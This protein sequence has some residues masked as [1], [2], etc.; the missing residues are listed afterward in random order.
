MFGMRLNRIQSKED[1][2]SL[3]CVNHEYYHYFRED[4]REKEDSRERERARKSCVRRLATSNIHSVSLFAY[5]VDNRM[6]PAAVFVSG[7]NEQQRSMKEGRLAARPTGWQ[8][9]NQLS[10]LH[11]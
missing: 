10:L 2:G 11:A 9:C 1:P 6:Q 5:L 8:G 3:V 7:Y 4:S